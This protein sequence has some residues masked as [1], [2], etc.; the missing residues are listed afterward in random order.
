MRNISNLILK[1][2]LKSIIFPIIIIIINYHFIQSWRFYFEKQEP[3]TLFFHMR[4]YTSR[5]ITLFMV[6]TI[7][8]YIN[9]HYDEIKLLVQSEFK[10]FLGVVYGVLKFVFIIC[11]I[12]II[13]MVAYSILKGF[14]SFDLVIEF[15]KM[16]L[17]EWILPISAV[18]IM[19]G[20]ISMY[21]KNKIL[22][23]ILSGAVFYFTSSS[24]LKYSIGSSNVIEQTFIRYI[25]LFSDMAYVK[26]SYCFGVVYDLPYMLDKS[27]CI[28]II[29]LCILLAYIMSSYKNKK[30]ILLSLITVSACIS[31]A[32]VITSRISNL[33]AYADQDIEYNQIH[34]ESNYIIKNYNM[35]LN[36]KSGLN[37]NIN[38]ELEKLQGENI[39][40]YLDDIFEIQDIR[41]NDKKAD[42][43]KKNNILTIFCNENSKSL[44][45][46]IKYRG[47]VHV[48]TTWYK[49]M[50]IANS[51]KIMLPKNSIAWYPKP[52]NK[53]SI[54]FTL[55][56]TSKNKVYCNLNLIKDESKNRIKKYKYK[57]KV[58]DLFVYSGFYNEKV[59][60]GIK[61]I[62]PQDLSLKNEL[63]IQG[64]RLNKIRKKNK[65]SI[66]T[67]IF[68]RRSD[69]SLGQEIDNGILCLPLE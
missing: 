26:P 33:V 67:V 15:F 27:A 59:I 13:Y 18:G 61:Y 20:F 51:Q 45:V 49:Y 6:I 63:D 32:F 25:S 16:L 69:Y 43:T 58:E 46:N 10:Y 66:K 30:R 39:K 56:I 2:L 4:S 37:N 1:V 24:V 28:I 17:Y 31:I 65:D 42:Y 68:G 48:I 44:K 35:D 3:F 52:I 34:E 7:I 41:I 50:Y 53:D 57:G 9:M 36:F 62:W 8:Y 29:L 23:Y 19:T 47:F 21:L 5:T 11:I 22:K 64:S 14:D 38:I 12:P 55:N 60:D 40:F 54:N